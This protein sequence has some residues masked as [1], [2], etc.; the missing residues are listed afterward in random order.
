VKAV[1]NFREEVVRPIIRHCTLQWFIFGQLK[2]FTE[3]RILKILDESLEPI[4]LRFHSLEEWKITFGLY[5]SSEQRPCCFQELTC[6]F[7]L[8]VIT[9]R[10]EQESVGGGRRQV[11]QRQ[12]GHR[13][14]GGRHD[15][16]DDGRVKRERE[17]FKSP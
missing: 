5:D 12:T 13:S 10:V 16:R 4:F 3:A 6:T 17:T 1:L 7:V 14:G 15:G 11:R 9:L 2:A 8:R